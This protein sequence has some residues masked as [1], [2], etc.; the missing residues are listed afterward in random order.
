MLRVVFA[1]ICFPFFSM[2]QVGIGTTTPDAKAQLDVNSTTK[3]FLPPRMLQ[4][5]RLAINPS[6]PGL[7]VYQT[8]APTGLYYY[9]GSAWIYIINSTTDVLPVINGG[10]GV[11]TSTGTGSVVLSTSPSLTT[12]S[13][14]NATAS[15]IISPIITGGSGITQTLTFKTTSGTGSTGADH[16]FLVGNNGATE[17]LRIQNNGNVGIGTSSPGATLDVKGTIRLSGA[18]SGFVGLSTAA[19]AGSTTYRLPTADGT[20]GQF[21]KTSG[22]GVLSWASDGGA[23]SINGLSDAK[24]EDGSIYLGRKPTTTS[25][26]E[27]NVAVGTTSLYSITTGDNNI[28]VG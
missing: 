24:V 3:G 16:I 4:S 14:G 11:T 13:L 8:D 25:T 2:A 20:S 12:P 9:N 18:T 22:S 21:L 15:S 23:T 1:L 19:A 17:G 27:N 26:A 7:M 28:A 5:Q 6:T 10:T